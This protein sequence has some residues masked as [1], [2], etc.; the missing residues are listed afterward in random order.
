MIKVSFDP[1]ST[2]SK[3]MWGNESTIHLDSNLLF[4]IFPFSLSHLLSPPYKSCPPPPLHPW[5]KWCKYIFLVFF[6]WSASLSNFPAIFFFHFTSLPPLNLPP[7]GPIQF[8]SHSVSPPPSDITSL[9]IFL[10]FIYSISHTL[11]SFVG[12]LFFYL[13][14]HTHFNMHSHHCFSPPHSNSSQSN[15]LIPFLLSH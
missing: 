5:S 9:H 1:K 2:Q 4:S 14:L 7:S 11:Q 8:L 10:H 15:L 12:Y 6:F 3:T 13:F